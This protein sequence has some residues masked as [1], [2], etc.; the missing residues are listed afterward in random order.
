V[1]ILTSFVSN[2]SQ[3]EDI[4]DLEYRVLYFRIMEITV[5]MLIQINLYFLYYT[6]EY[7]TW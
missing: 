3:F 4:L 7:M 6:I 1:D 2:F 5:L